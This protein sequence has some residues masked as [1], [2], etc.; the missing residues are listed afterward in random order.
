MSDPIYP[1]NQP[2]VNRAH[3]ASMDE[4]EKTYQKSVA[5]P[6][7]FWDQQASRLTFFEPYDAENSGMVTERVFRNLFVNVGEGF[8]DTEVDDLIYDLQTGDQETPVGRVNYRKF[9][10]VMFQE[11]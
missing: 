10:D 3:I 7:D 9:V 11:L 8:S 4:Y 1:P 6:E 5:D 2:L